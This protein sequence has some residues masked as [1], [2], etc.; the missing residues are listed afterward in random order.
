MNISVVILTYNEESHIEDCLA[1]ILRQ[2]YSDG[3]WE[4]LV[5]DGMST[6][7]TRPV[8]HG[9]QKR[10]GPIRVID[11]QR[12]TIASGRNLGIF[13]SQYPFVAFT[14]ADCVVPENWLKN[15]SREYEILSRADPKIAGVGGANVPLAGASRFQKALGLCLNSFL[16]SLNSV[17]GRNFQETRRVVSLAC[18]NVLYHKQSIV[19]TGGFDEAL[20]NIAEDLDLGL[21][22]GKKGYHLYF[23]PGLPV[24]HKLRPTLSSWLRNMALY[25]RG[26]ARVTFKHHLFKSP[27]FLFP[28]CFLIGMG[29]T[30]LGFIHPVFG[31]PLLYFAF[32]GLSVLGIAVREKETGLAGRMILILVCT[33]FVYAFHLLIHSLRILLNQRLETLNSR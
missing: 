3:E 12:R 14:D 11:N 20:G 25:G 13:A 6:D 8:I 28:F 30:P 32:T 19:E 15:L 23:V 26:R 9:M 21:R 4:V 31:L 24:F 17:Q 2:R 5:V 16:G 18:L 27:F 7:N 22:L 1:S 29:V 33:H 10:Y